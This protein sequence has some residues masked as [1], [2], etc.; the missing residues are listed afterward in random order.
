MPVSEYRPPVVAPRHDARPDVMVIFDLACRLGYGEHF[1]GGDVEAALRWQV[2]PSG[3]DLDTLRATPGGVDLPVQQRYRKY[4]AEDAGPA[5]PPA[6][7][8]PPAR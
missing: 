6:S 5:T 7:A 8:R 3:V 4:A 1:F 2:A